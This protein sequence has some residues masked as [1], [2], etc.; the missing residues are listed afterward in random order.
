MTTSADTRPRSGFRR[1]SILLT[2]LFLLLGAASAGVYWWTH[3][4]P[5]A[6]VPPSVPDNRAD[7]EVA[8][9]VDKV[10]GDVFKEPRSARTWGRLGQAFLANDMEAEAAFCFIEAER[11]D[12]ANPRWPYYRAGILVNQ[13]EPEAALPLF[14][15][16]VACGEAAA[17]DNLVP[18][19]MA[20]ETLLAL[21]RLD[22]AEEQFRQVLARRPEETRA[23]YGLALVCAARPD[24]PTSR[25][26][27]L[28]CLDN[29]FVQRKACVQLAG[30][31]RR[32]GEESEAE[33]FRQ[34]SDRLPLDRDWLDPFV[35]EYLPWVVKKSKRYH[36]A[37]SLEAMGQLR[38]AAKVLLPLAVD[39]PNDYLPRL[40]LAK[41]IGRLGDHARAEQLLREALLLA[42][43]KVQIHYYLSLVLFT[44]AE[45]E[46]R[47][48]ERARAE[49]LYREAVQRA[50]AALALK[51]DYGF[52]YMTL[53]LSLKGLAQRGD[54][55]TALREAI[56]CNPEHAELHFYLG[57][58]L[59]ED[60]RRN[61]AREQ[62]E[63]ALE[64]APANVP[65]H[66]RA[67]AGLA[68]S[69]ADATEPRP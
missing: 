13:G 38:E 33:K 44:H 37:E 58:L 34:Q 18:R 36:H 50:R 2:A 41:V 35:T 63:R 14:Q 15:R 30:V 45:A 52:A 68:A 17:S 24:W 65:W 47:K 26:H 3:R 67:L 29:P 51:P 7:R 25:T 16:A 8:A 19:L 20:A 59:I 22:E 53:G 64:M 48:G 21:G 4:T 1:R 11:L 69:K 5:P 49:Q 60:G 28:R 10:R 62:F 42:P 54:A 40:A 6:P 66:S 39:N 46:A 57:E 23:H 12:A 43:D 61:E 9:I 55:L 32:L 27:L 31:C 56:R